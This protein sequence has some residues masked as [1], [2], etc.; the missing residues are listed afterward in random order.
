[1][2]TELLEEHVV[3]L[4]A[5]MNSTF[6]CP[7]NCEG[8]KTQGST[9][10]PCVLV[11]KDLWTGSQEMYMHVCA[12]CQLCT[13]KVAI[14]VCSYTLLVTPCKKLLRMNPVETESEGEKQ[15]KT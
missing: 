11:H 2:Q 15:R 12:A 4:F 8:T 7:S 3:G 5:L 13:G 1:M 6:L 10:E 14:L 9:I